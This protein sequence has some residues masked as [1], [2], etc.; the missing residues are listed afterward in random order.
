MGCPAICI[1]CA[2]GASQYSP[3][4]RWWLRIHV[5]ALAV[6]NGSQPPPAPIWKVEKLPRIF[7]QESE[8]KM[9]QKHPVR[10]VVL[11]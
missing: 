9:M 6:K 4:G 5:T 7:L 8:G 11:S 1:M 10:K 2:I 3:S